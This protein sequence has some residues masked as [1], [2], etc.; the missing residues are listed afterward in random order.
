MIYYIFYTHQILDYYNVQLK[1]A[2]NMTHCQN[3]HFQIAHLILFYI[4]ECLDSLHPVV[5]NDS[6]KAL[7]RR[8]FDD[9][10]IDSIN[11]DSHMDEN[12]KN[13]ENLDGN[14]MTSLLNFTHKKYN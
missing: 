12:Y 5:E 14:F 4:Y 3:Y 1:K 2:Y 7:C 9:M 11:A 8:N 13:N 6:F 10:M